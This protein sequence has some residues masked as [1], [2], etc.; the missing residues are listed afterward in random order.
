MLLATAP[1]LEDID[2]R[3]EDCNENA[4][5]PQRIKDYSGVAPYALDPNNADA[6]GRNRYA[7]LLDQVFLNRGDVHGH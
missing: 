3:D 7:C 5:V 2:D 4:T 1:L 6:S